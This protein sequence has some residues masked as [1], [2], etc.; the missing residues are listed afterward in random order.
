MKIPYDDQAILLHDAARLCGMDGHIQTVGSTAAEKIML[1]FGG[2]K[3]TPRKMS[4]LYCD[5]V[6]ACF[7]FSN[8][9]PCCV[10]TA[11]WFAGAKDLT[12]DKMLTAVSQIRDML[13]K[14]QELTDAYLK[15][16]TEY[17]QMTIFDS[18]GHC[19]GLE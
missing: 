13:T 10:I 16:S 2:K 19:D 1:Y 4:Y 3:N 8:N 17:E 18:Y 9:K 12:D 11:R 5:S 15:A 6:D 7:Y 14:M